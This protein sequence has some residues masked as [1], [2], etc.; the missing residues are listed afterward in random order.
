MAFN[1]ISATLKSMIY[2]TDSIAKFDKDEQI[3]LKKLAYSKYEKIINMIN[4]QSPIIDKE[5]SLYKLEYSTLAFEKISDICND[6]RDNYVNVIDSTDTCLLL[7]S[8]SV[9][10]LANYLLDHSHLDNVFLTLNY[11][12]N[13]SSAAHQ[14]CI[15]FDNANRKVYM[16]DPNGRSTFFNSI[17]G[18]DMN[19]YVELILAKYVA[20]LSSYGLEYE[21][22]TCDR[23]NK[24]EIVL[25]KHFKNDVLDPGH[26][27]ITTLLLIHMVNTYI[28]P[29][30]AIQMFKHLTDDELLYFI[31][32]YS[33]GVYQ[34][35]C[36]NS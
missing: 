7:N 34:L 4:S 21:Y 25:N 3:K 15:Y 22:I 35:L 1:E 14:S 18:Q 33:I 30:L 28:D 11:G 31:R 8:L 20:E 5:Y 13:L 26:C 23:W 6:K 19:Y 27:V 32:E 10:Y 17:F 24:D 36:T 2:N 29:S 16:L 12:S 9:E